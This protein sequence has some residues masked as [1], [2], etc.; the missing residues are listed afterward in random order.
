MLFNKWRTLFPQSDYQKRL[1]GAHTQCRQVCI[2]VGCVPSAAVAIWGGRRVGVGVCPV[3]VCVCAMGQT[4]ARPPVDRMTDACENVTFP[5]LLSDWSL[6]LFT[7]TSWLLLMAVLLRFGRRYLKEP[8]LWS[9]VF[10][11]TAVPVP[12]SASSFFWNGNLSKDH[13][14]WRYF[15]TYS[16]CLMS[17]IKNMNFKDISCARFTLYKK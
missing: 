16:S 7:P 5:Q 12:S 13:E 14:N 2:P 17:T 10:F 11:S 4:P 8:V 6:I 1:N 15:C 3:C 9:L